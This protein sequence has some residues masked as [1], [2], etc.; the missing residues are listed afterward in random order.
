M[1]TAILLNL[2]P[3]I[4]ILVALAVV[5]WL[6]SRL[7]TAPTTAAYSERSRDAYRFHRFAHAPA[8]EARRAA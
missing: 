6:P 7:R 8:D 5:C 1:I 4:F 3:A 2:I